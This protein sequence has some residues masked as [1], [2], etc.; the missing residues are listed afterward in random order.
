MKDAPRIMT[1]GANGSMYREKLGNG[2]SV[3]ASWTAY[4]TT[5]K[6]AIR[7]SGMRRSRAA[8]KGAAKTGEA[9]S[10]ERGAKARP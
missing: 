10:K 5:A 4:H 1:N 9:E 2:F 7:R 6:L 8:T 3:V